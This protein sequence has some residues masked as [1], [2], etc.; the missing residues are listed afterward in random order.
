MSASVQVRYPAPSSGPKLT[1]SLDSGTLTL[2]AG[3]ASLS[4]GVDEPIA[5]ASPF[6]FPESELVTEPEEEGEQEE[7]GEDEVDGG[8]EQNRVQSSTNSSSLADGKFLIISKAKR[9]D[10]SIYHTKDV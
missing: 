5:F 10:Y 8:G 7:E 4:L 3:C 1:A 9:T 2:S 6:L